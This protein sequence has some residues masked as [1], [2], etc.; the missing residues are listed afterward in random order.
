[1]FS[2]KQANTHN[3][4]DKN[5]NLGF[6]AKKWNC[7][8]KPTKTTYVHKYVVECDR[9]AHKQK[10]EPH[11][12]YTVPTRYINNSF[13]VCGQQRVFIVFLS[14]CW[15]INIYTWQY[16]IL[17]KHSHACTIGCKRLRGTSWGYLGCTVGCEDHFGVGCTVLATKI[18]LG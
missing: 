6:H 18:T 15:H 9:S 11:G 4:R 3:T 2:Q 7:F 12:S 13:C 10:W 5:E 17:Y 16:Y 8:P 14:C 1:M